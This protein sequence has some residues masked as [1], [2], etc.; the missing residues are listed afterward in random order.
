[1]PPGFP[2]AF[3]NSVILILSLQ[4]KY[5]MVRVRQFAS[6]S[7][8]FLII[9]QVH[10][11]T[12]QEIIPIDSTK[13]RKPVEIPIFLAGNFGELRST[14]YH[15]GID[16]KTQGKTGLNLYA[17]EDGWIS[18]IGINAGGY[19]NVLYI[20][21][22]SGYTSVYAHM[23][24][25]PKAVADY[26]L[27]EQYKAK[28]F[29][30]NLY[31]TKGMFAY[32][33]GDVVGKSGNSGRSGG[34]H[35]HFEIRNTAN[36]DVLN[37]QLFY[38]DITDN[39]APR[40]FKISIYPAD[41]QS[42][43]NKKN[44][45]ISFAVSKDS[46]PE[47]KAW[48][49]F[50]FGIEAEDFYDGSQNRCGLYSIQLLMDS[51]PV[52]ETQ[53]DKLR[54]SEARS[55]LS[56]VDYATKI[57]KG[58]TYQKSYVEPNNQTNFY[59]FVNNDQGKVNLF[60]NEVH[61]FEYIIKDIQGNSAKTKFKIKG[62]PDFALL[63]FKE[64]PCTRIMHWD[65]RNVFDSLNVTIDISEKTLFDDIHF[66]FSVDKDTSSY[67][68]KIYQIHNDQTPVLKFFTISI[69]YSGN[70]PDKDKLLIARVET[71][72]NNKKRLSYVGGKWDEDGYV[73]TPSRNFGAFTISVDTVPPEIKDLTKWA[74]LKANPSLE[75]KALD[76]LSGIKTYQGSID[77]EWI[78]IRYDEKSDYFTHRLDERTIT[79]NKKHKL[80]FEVTDNRG[81]VKKLEKEFVY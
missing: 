61:T 55:I 39:T 40:M 80:V 16:I 34:P 79:R 54:F 52:Y 38:Q 74:A 32:K 25:F 46:V 78:L 71:D 72:K 41:Y 5:S 31:P 50:Y 22:E 36:E 1:M 56:Y 43:I 18:R 24:S 9:L 57:S 26:I 14:H 69:P 75:F 10:F 44:D 27:K 48:G 17:I 59:R 23:E 68:S 12:A 66:T 20:S 15:T 45:R 64:E 49:Q 62:N 35:L 28:A 58:V 73:S 8:L 11:L 81:N 19:G 51:K 29:E 67:L 53:V 7:A 77:G 65:E 30:I 60:D 63:D 37:P 4:K 6:V 47:F 13:F 33:K 21:H 76:R 3:S 2:I 42:V 70:F